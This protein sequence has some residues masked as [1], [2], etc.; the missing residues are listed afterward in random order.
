VSGPS[1]PRGGGASPAAQRLD[2]WA[3][4]PGSRTRRP[5]T[6][7]RRPPMRRSP[8]R[9]SNAPQWPPTH[10]GPPCALRRPRTDS[11]RFEP[12]PA[13]GWVQR[14]GPMPCRGNDKP[15]QA[16]KP[17]DGDAEPQEGPPAMPT[18]APTAAADAFRGQEATQD[19]PA[20][21][22]APAAPLR[23]RREV[24]SSSPAA[25]RMRQHRA[26]KA[27]R[28]VFNARLRWPAMFRSA[29]LREA[30]ELRPCT[31]ALRQ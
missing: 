11:C 16:P 31:S 30:A 8:S 22:N 5:R 23:A 3:S 14:G 2:C 28:C 24:L 29:I 25:V 13:I 4:A 17:A 1:D 20:P 18:D 12:A 10:H 6:R 19:T 7:H 27:S 21:E 9:L 26:N 15:R